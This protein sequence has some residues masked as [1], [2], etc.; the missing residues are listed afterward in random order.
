MP[1]SGTDDWDKAFVICAGVAVSAAVLWGLCHAVVERRLICK[2]IL[3]FIKG[4]STCR[5]KKNQAE[6]KYLDEQVAL[7]KKNLAQ[8]VPRASKKYNMQLYN[9][10][11]LNTFHF[12]IIYQAVCLVCLVLR[13]AV[14][15]GLGSPPKVFFVFLCLAV[16][17][18]AT[19][20]YNV[21]MERPRWMSTGQSK[22][23]DTLRVE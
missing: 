17:N 12:K 6:V 15:E 8:K 7:E 16:Y 14:E 21:F 10:V 9:I 1:W 11:E 13:K 3:A 20:L 5:S 4:L 2:A 22:T 18:L 19:I 23:G